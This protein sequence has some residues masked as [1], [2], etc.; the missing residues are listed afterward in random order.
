M[1][2]QMPEET[3]QQTPWFLDTIQGSQ[4]HWSAFKR[5]ATVLGYVSVHRLETQPGSTFQTTLIEGGV[6][7]PPRFGITEATLDDDNVAFRVVIQERGPDP[8][9]PYNTDALY[10]LVEEFLD[11]A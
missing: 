4:A 5:A 3:S 10:E 6:R 2:E 11:E 7:I 9:R 1:S 8:E